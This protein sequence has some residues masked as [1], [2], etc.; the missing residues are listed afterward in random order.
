MLVEV[1]VFGFGQTLFGRLSLQQLLYLTGFSVVVRWSMT[2]FASSGALILTAQALHGMTYAATHLLMMR[3]IQQSDPKQAV[4]LQAAYNGLSMCLFLG[5][6]SMI[7]GWL[8]DQLDGYVFLVMACLGVPVF[9]WSIE[10][11]SLWARLL[12]SRKKLV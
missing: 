1:L 7:S 12:A 9:F 4:P 3:F 6:A 10:S 8:F 11:E 5:I 2:A